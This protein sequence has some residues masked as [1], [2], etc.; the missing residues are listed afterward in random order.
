MHKLIDCAIQYQERLLE[1]ISENKFDEAALRTHLVENYVLVQDIYDQKEEIEQSE[2]LNLLKSQIVEKLASHPKGE[3]ISRII[4]A[5]TTKVEDN[6]IHIDIRNEIGDQSVSR[7]VIFSQNIRANVVLNDESKQSQDRMDYVFKLAPTASAFIKN[8]IEEHERTSIQNAVKNI[9][10]NEWKKILQRYHEM[11]EGDDIEIIK[12]HIHNI[13][14]PVVEPS[15]IQIIDSD[16]TEQE[17]S[18][19]GRRMRLGKMRE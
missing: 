1:I 17:E 7:P 9:T 18:L 14:A 10:D 8:F 11:N 2:Q 16:D 15:N 6:V 13:I 12:V 4:E 19:P 5:L 3:I